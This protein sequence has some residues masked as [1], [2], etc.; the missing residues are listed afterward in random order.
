MTFEHLDIHPET[1]DDY[2][3]IA[4]LHTAAAERFL[5]RGDGRIAE[6][7][8][9]LAHRNTVIAEHLSTLGRKATVTARAA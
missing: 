6:Q 7:Y 3:K 1:P 9:D 8:L 5:G 4:R 2:R